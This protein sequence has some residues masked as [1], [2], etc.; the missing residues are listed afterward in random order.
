MHPRAIQALP[1][2]VC[3]S[4]SLTLSPPFSLSIWVALVRGR[5]AVRQ[6][7]FFMWSTADDFV[8]AWGGVALVNIPPC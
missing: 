2:L 6:C 4:L 1:I 7:D 8:R 5:L 3:A